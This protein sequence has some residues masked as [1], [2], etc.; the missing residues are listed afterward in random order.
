VLPP[1]SSRLRR[2]IDEIMKMKVV[3]IAVAALALL[4]PSVAQS[5]VF[6]TVKGLLSAQFKQSERVTFV[7][8]E[9]DKK[10]RADIAKRLGHPLPRATYSFYV[11]KSGGGVDGYAL[12]DAELGQHEPIDFATFFDRNGKIT[13]V[14]VVA[15]RE[16]YGADIR[17]QQFRRQF[18]GRTAK[19][20]FRA[21]KDID[22]ISG[23]TISSKSAARAVQRA[24]VLLDQLVLEKK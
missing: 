5:E 17:K 15:Y 16:A 18:V 10:Q 21:G 23:A 7:R 12:F 8:V 4:L 11:A 2:G 6:H 19:S 1:F 14:E 24:T 13:R 9:P 22:I 20:G 3:F